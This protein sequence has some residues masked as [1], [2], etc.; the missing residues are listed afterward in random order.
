MTRAIVS[1]VRRYKWRVMSAIALLVIWAL[2]V[3]V[4]SPHVPLPTCEGIVVFPD[5]TPVQLAAQ[6]KPPVVAG[7]VVTAPPTPMTVPRLIHVIEATMPSPVEY[8]TSAYA[9]QQRDKVMMATSSSSGP[10]YVTMRWNLTGVRTWMA[11]TYAWYIPLF[12]SLN[13]EQQTQVAPY[14]LLDAFGG[15]SFSPHYVP[16]VDLHPY[17]SPD[18]VSFLET[19]APLWEPVSTAVIASAAHHPLWTIVHTRLLESPHT[20]GAALLGQMEMQHPSMVYLL[21]CRYFNRISERTT[22]WIQKNTRLRKKCGVE[23]D[24]C[25]FGALHRQ[26]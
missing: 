17:L 5:P 19:N 21:P 4:Y 24:P 26:S 13:A 6:G 9:A 20:V 1:Q 23:S 15:I 3:A 14:F 11:E 25:L 12:D 10:S 2:Y 16:R 7:G 18:R 8:A 22:N